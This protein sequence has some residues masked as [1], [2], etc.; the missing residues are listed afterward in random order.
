MRVYPNPT[1]DELVIEHAA[2]GSAIKLL[3]M[4]GQVLYGGIVNSEHF[5]VST[6]N[7]VSGMYI[8]QVADDAGNR[9]TK[10]IVKQ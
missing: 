8:L 6:R 2:T 5:V 4:M 3:N 10:T 7:L 9:I 1:T